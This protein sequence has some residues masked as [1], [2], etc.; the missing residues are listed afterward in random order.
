MERILSIA[1]FLT[2]GAP[3]V[4]VMVTRHEPIPGIGSG[5][6]SSGLTT[7]S[8]APSPVMVMDCITRFDVP[9]LF[10]ATILGVEAPP[11]FTE[12]KFNDAGFTEIFGGVSALDGPTDKKMHRVM[13]HVRR[14]SQVTCPRYFDLLIETT[15]AVGILKTVSIEHEMRTL[16][17]KI[18]REQFP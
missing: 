4:N 15:F 5:Q 6:P 9:V 14:I 11:A 3:G 1:L 10:I 2:K 8:E 16:V 7:N 18:L 12:P 13:A 17:K